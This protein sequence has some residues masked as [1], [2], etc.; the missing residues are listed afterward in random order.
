MRNTCVECVIIGHTRTVQHTDTV[1]IHS[2]D[3]YDIVI[4]CDPVSVFDALIDVCDGVKKYLTD[5]CDLMIMP[6]YNLMCP[7]PILR[8]PPCAMSQGRTKLHLYYMFLSL[9]NSKIYTVFE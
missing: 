9:C 3:H 5:R 6:L 7:E 8:S 4:T 1:F 2:R